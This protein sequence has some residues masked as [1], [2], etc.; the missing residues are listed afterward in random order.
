MKLI[1]YPHTNHL[2]ES[3]QANDVKFAFTNK[4]DSGDYQLIT[5][6]VKCREYFNE[7]LMKNHHPTE[8]DFN[9][10]YGFVYKHEEYPYN[11]T[12]PSMLISLPKKAM[13]E[14]FK[15]NLQLLN[16]IEDFSNIPKS[17]LVE[18]EEQSTK[19]YKFIL[20]FSPT[21]I[22]NCILFNIYT[23]LI[24][25]CTLNIKDNSVKSLLNSYDKYNIPSELSYVKGIT[26]KV[27]NSILNNL[28][29]L[30]NIKSKYV[31]GFDTIR[32]PYDIHGYSGL[33][34]FLE[35]PNTNTQK[36]PVFKV[37]DQLK[38]QSPE[39]EFIKESS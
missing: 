18:V 32:G 15:Q 14:V 36:S 29:E 12:N 4:L 10:V 37:L 26:T 9:E 31:D 3:M 34:T 30:I 38:N 23:L 19:G 21:W 2:C 39:H 35:Y 7:F 6:S 1:P 27:F 16:T 28:K 13:Y 20:H 24:K 5:N 33:L 25:L 22:T 8:F 17:Y 11:M